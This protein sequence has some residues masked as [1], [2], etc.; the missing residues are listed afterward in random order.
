MKL[1]V[2]GHTVV[3]RIITGQDEL[4]KPGGIYYSILGLINFAVDTDEIFLCS[5]L[6]KSDEYLFSDICYT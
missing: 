3:D 2:I 4:I 5:I 6:S 1:L